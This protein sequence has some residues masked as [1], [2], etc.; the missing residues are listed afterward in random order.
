[1]LFLVTLPLA[2]FVAIAIK[3]DS[4]GPIFVRERKFDRYGRCFFALKFRIAGNSGS[5]SYAELTCVGNIIHF[6]QIDNLPQL[7]NVLRG[8]M[9]CIPG[10][11]NIPYFLD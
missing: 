10:D 11:P 8:E 4:P 6:L 1:M 2:I 7:I 5:P 3:L 9:G